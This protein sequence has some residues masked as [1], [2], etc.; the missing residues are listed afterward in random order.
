MNELENK[1]R[2]AGVDVDRARLTEIAFDALRRLP[3]QHSAARSVA[4]TVLG[5]AGLLAALLGRDTIMTAVAEFVSA[6]ANDMRGGASQPADES[7]SAGDRPSPASFTPPSG[8]L[9]QAES[10]HSGDPGS[11]A[12]STSGAASRARIESQALIDR[13]DRSPS[14][15][16]GASLTGKESHGKPDRPTSLPRTSISKTAAQAVAKSHSVFNVR[17][18]AETTLGDMTRFDAINMRRK[19]T[20]F[21]HI[22]DRTLTEIRWPDDN[23]PLKACCSEEKAR[24]IYES[25]YNLLGRVPEDQRHVR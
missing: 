25:G 3:N 24:E 19:T 1:L 20:A 6:R 10:H 4:T 12:P 5:D 2:D 18:G 13:S 21:A 23:T 9:G 14:T 15:A 11:A 8:S 22:L 17:L 7:Q 16:G